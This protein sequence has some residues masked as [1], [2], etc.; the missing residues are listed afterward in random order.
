MG[1]STF[2]IIAVSIIPTAV[3]CF[4]P[5]T[6]CHANHNRVWVKTEPSSPMMFSPMRHPPISL[7]EKA[8]TRR[9]A[10]SASTRSSLE[11][12]F[13]DADG[14]VVN[15][16]VRIANHIPTLITI[17]YFGL[18]SSAMMGMNPSSI[19]PATLTSVLTKRVGPTTQA[20]FSS[21]FPTLVTPASFVF[22]IWPFISVT[23]L[24]TLGVSAL[25]PGKLPLFS[26]S[27]LSSLSLANLCATA[28]LFISSQA[29]GASVPLGSFLV[30]PAVAI[31][32][33]YPLRRRA[34]KLEARKLTGKNFIF[35]VYS[36]F[37]T[38]ASLLAFAVELLYGGRIPFFAGKEELVALIYLVLFFDV[39]YATNNSFVKRA[40]CLF[41]ISGIL[42][43]R[44]V[45]G[46]LSWMNLPSLLVTAA[47]T[48]ILAKNLPKGKE[49]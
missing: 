3:L 34:N 39:G 31:F 25:G 24:V 15:R 35:Q 26:Q 40:V 37:T 6:A 18:I 23:Q 30:L 20:A 48:V 16:L 12:V 43:N 21:L 41:A 44:L 13:K 32:S 22:L 17:Y 42:W 29:T 38:L 19:G 36:S 47:V 5:Q 27:E 14:A 10:L 2:W 11:R 9:V 1:F 49:L 4:A 45:A 7:H 46:A 28:W 8:P 33:G